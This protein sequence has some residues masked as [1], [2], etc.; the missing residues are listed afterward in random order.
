MVESNTEKMDVEEIDK[1]EQDLKGLSIKTKEKK[2]VQFSS[3]MS[4]FAEGS[5]IGS[6]AKGKA[7]TIAV[8]VSVA[9]KLKRQKKTKSRIE[10]GKIYSKKKLNFGEDDE[11]DDG[12]EKEFNHEATLKK[13][14]PQ[15][16]SKTL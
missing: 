6:H 7:L 11:Q 14:M 10:I 5:Q 16:L 15:A 12:P 4:M 13:G 8:V 3:P 1:V 9:S 2:T